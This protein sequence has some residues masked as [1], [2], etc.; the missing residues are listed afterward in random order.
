MEVIMKIIKGDFINGSA[1]VYKKANGLIVKGLQFEDDSIHWLPYWY[2]GEFYCDRAVIDTGKKMGHIDRFGNEI[3]PPTYSVVDDFSE[4]R[5]FVSNGDDTILIDTNGNRIT[6]LPE[7]FVTSEYHD[8][9]AILSRI[10]SNGE[11]VEEAVVDREGRFLINFTLKRKINTL[12][13]IHFH[14]PDSFWHEGIRKFS[15]NGK[16]GVQDR[17]GNEVVNDCVG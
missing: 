10:V 11:E 9:S 4:E 16:L 15:R 14:P 8:G 13:D 3:I 2:T 17:Y 6:W 12:T 5:A 1:V 7:A